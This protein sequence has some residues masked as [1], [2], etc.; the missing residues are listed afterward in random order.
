VASRQRPWFR[1]HDRA[2]TSKSQRALRRDYD[3]KLNY[4]DRSIRIYRLT[5]ER[6]I[7]ARKVLRGR[8]QGVD[9]DLP[10]SLGIGKIIHRAVDE[11]IERHGLTEGETAK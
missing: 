10:T 8:M 6:L 3:P 9:L 7:A 11:Y 1:K 5:Y 2:K 4:C